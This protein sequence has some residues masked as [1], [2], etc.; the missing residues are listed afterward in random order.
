MTTK[1]TLKKYDG[2]NIEIG[3]DILKGPSL[4]RMKKLKNAYD[5]AADADAELRGVR[6]EFTISGG[7]VRKRVISMTVKEITVDIENGTIIDF[8]LVGTHGG[9]AILAVYDPTERTGRVHVLG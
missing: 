4:D 9:V 2:F 7:N 3:Y 5:A 1:F 8:G 6:V